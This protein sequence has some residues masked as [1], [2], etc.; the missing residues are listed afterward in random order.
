M[1]IEQ[2]G[3]ESAENQD[4][5]VSVTSASSCSK[6]FVFFVSLWLIL[7]FFAP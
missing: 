4:G 7:D 1:N 6:S 5:L 2:E 3:A